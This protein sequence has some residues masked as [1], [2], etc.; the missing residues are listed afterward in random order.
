[1]MILGKFWVIVLVVLAG[2]GGMRATR[3][4]LP[5]AEPDVVILPRSRG[6]GATK[7][8]ISVAVI[9]LQD[10]KDLDGFGVLIVNESPNW[11]SLK[12]EDCMLIQSG[13]VRY[14]LSE[15]Q[16]SSRLGSSYKPRMPGELNIDIFEWRRDINMMNSRDLKIMDEDEKLS[17]MRG[18]KERIFLYFRTRDDTAPIQL[19]IPKLLNEAT[20][21]RTLFSFKF[22]V[23]R[24]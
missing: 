2:C 15:A 16:A 19:I 21:Q 20:E 1:V 3:D 22:A 8:N 10:V 6:V 13:E 24:K 12:K 18:T 9:P 11:I 5:V 17:I 4:I 14:P 23:E 7:D